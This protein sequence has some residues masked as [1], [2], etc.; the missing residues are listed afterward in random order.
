MGRLPDQHK[1]VY[2]KL[3]KSWRKGKS[4]LVSVS[5]LIL[6]IHTLCGEISGC[7]LDRTKVWRNGK[8]RLLLSFIQ[9]HKEMCSSTISPWLKETLVLSGVTKILD[10]WGHSIRS[11]STLKAELPGLSVKEVLDRGS[12]SNESTWQKFYHKEIINVGKD[13]QKNVFKM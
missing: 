11:A 10:F 1:F 9:P 4:P 12:W 2:T 13:Y 6:R 3:H 7:F 5:L 8:N